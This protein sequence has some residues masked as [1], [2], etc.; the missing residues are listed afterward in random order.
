MKICL[1]GHTGFIGSNLFNHM[2]EKYE[3]YVVN[4]S[5][6]S[7]ELF[8]TE[9]DFAINCAGVSHKYQTNHNTFTGFETETSILKTL[10]KIQF[11]KLIHISSIDSQDQSNYGKLKK[12]VEQCVHQQYPTATIIRPAGFVGPQL[13][14]NIVFDIMN[15]NVV[16]ALPNSKFNYISI[17]AFNEIIDKII[18]IRLEYPFVDVGASSSVYVYEIAAIFNKEPSYTGSRIYDYFVDIGGLMNFYQPKT[19]FEYVKEF[20]NENK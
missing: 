5:E 7:E 1:I 11:K 20:A 17:R 16:F 18:D 3:I 9:F 15:N 8:D 2:Q 13:K 4:S 6:H 19:S 10:S 14:K 12:L